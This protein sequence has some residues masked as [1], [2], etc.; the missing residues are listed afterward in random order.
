MAKRWAQIGVAFLLVLVLCVAGVLV[1]RNSLA[2][3]LLTLYLSDQGLD[4]VELEVANVDLDG[5]EIVD[6]TLGPELAVGRLEASYDLA[7]LS[8]GEVA[9]IEFNDVDLRIDLTGEEPPFKS[10]A[11]LFEGSEEDSAGALPTLLVNELRLA[12]ASPYGEVAATLDGQIVPRQDGT[13]EI[14][15]AYR[16]TGPYGLLSGTLTATVDGS[17]NG[18]GVLQIDEGELGLPDH[19][20][21]TGP[22]SGVVDFAM[23]ADQAPEIIA[24]L[25]LPALQIT[26]LPVIEAALSLEH[27]D[28]NFALDADLDAEDL[29]MR[30]SVGASDLET[31]P[32]IRLDGR[33]TLPEATELTRLVE[34][35][36]SLRA[37][38]TV[39]VA[40]EGQ[41]PGT[42]LEQLASLGLL[43]AKS[44][45]SGRLTLDRLAIFDQQRF[46][47]GT[48]DI[49]V[50]VDLSNG[51]LRLNPLVPAAI[52]LSEIGPA[53]LQQLDLPKDLAQIVRA[54]AAISLPSK[55]TEAVVTFNQQGRVTGLE[56]VLS[57]EITLAEGGHIRLRQNVNLAFADD[58]ALERA[59]L[60]SVELQGWDLALGDD[61]IGSLTLTG[62]VVGDPS[63]L[64]LR[65]GAVTLGDL[66]IAGAKL[67]DAQIALSGSASGAGFALNEI[68]ASFADLELDRLSLPNLAIEGSL[69][70]SSSAFRGDLFIE[71]SLPRVSDRSLEARDARLSAPLAFKVEDGV[72]E[73]VLG[74]GGNLRIAGIQLRPSLTVESGIALEITQGSLTYDLTGQTSGPDA[75]DLAFRPIRKGETW[76]WTM[77]LGQD[78]GE[79]LR[80]TVQPRLLRLKVRPTSKGGLLADVALEI[81]RAVA[82][83]FELEA[84]Q[85]KIDALFDPEKSGLTADL[86]VDVLRDLRQ[87][88]YF[89]PIGLAGRLS[90]AARKLDF[91]AGVTKPE[92]LSG[93]SV[94]GLHSLRHDAGHLT[95]N[96]GELDLSQSGLQP[97][98]LSPMMPSLS[99]LSGSAS[100][101]AE[102]TWTPGGLKSRA[103]LTLDSVSFSL[104]ETR[105]EGL[106]T[107][108]RFDDLLPPRSPPNQ[109]FSIRNLAGPIEIKGLQGLLQV[110]PGTPPRALIDQ[111][112]FEA[113]GGKFSLQGARIDPGQ[114]RHQ[115]ELGVI[116]LDLEM[117]TQTL[118][119]EGLS[120]T[121]I[122]AGKLPLV[123]D[124]GSLIIV[125]AELDSQGPGIIRYRSR[126]TQAL[127]KD[128]I[129][130]GN[131]DSLDLVDDPFRLTLLALGNFHYDSLRVQ[132]GNSAD[133]KANLALALNGKNPD[134]LDGYPFE[135][136][137][138]LDTN[139]LPLLKAIDEGLVVTKDLLPGTWRFGR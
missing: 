108:F 65:N 23:A 36:P 42:G 22:L 115:V 114:E 1:Y 37:A 134:I 55:G 10:L 91:S 11:P 51:K 60:E 75:I 85:I 12:I 137:V 95:L 52:E 101:S 41:L 72:L 123:L 24:T 88:P 121:G 92:A 28:G 105:V 98:Q 110:L 117:L 132:M 111:A 99:G 8:R 27:A 25:S 29:A 50:Q 125:D 59:D 136:K 66:T 17:F 18:Q 103:R 79:A 100:G 34:G 58:G 133:G 106:S 7:G 35:W 83:D 38:G 68:K 97:S 118:D 64:T 31:G 54:G 6:L 74:K 48:G 30:L 90:L 87:V 26:G 57:A 16:A 77:K 139:L 130:A 69:T 104:D 45:L 81:D 3:R 5:L 102:L 61:R 44:R 19:G 112:T 82:Q 113:L 94:A 124:R 122:L 32:K 96:L 39:V 13:F 56:A 9:Q 109:P 49:D 127:L 89:H 15:A 138:N 21:A 93:V 128:I 120:G 119:I 107:D 84:S 80:I 14:T 40:L 126:E 129:A 47:R 78:D 71:S 70:G 33:M 73:A 20:L 63:G 4:L 2:E 76:P 67:G 131:L 43:L 86:E 53:V 62:D 135:L 46:G 116:S